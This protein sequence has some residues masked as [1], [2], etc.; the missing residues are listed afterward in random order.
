[1]YLLLLIALSIAAYMYTVVISDH[2]FAYRLSV[3]K[4]YKDLTL[5]LLLF[6]LSG[7]KRGVFQN[8][9]YPFRIHLAG[10]MKPVRSNEIGF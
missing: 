1:M 6:F 5:L 2:T 8:Q 3:Q 10:R 9:L 4:K 7:H